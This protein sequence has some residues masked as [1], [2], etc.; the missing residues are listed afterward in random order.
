VMASRAKLDYADKL[1]DLRKQQVDLAGARVDAARADLSFV[2]ADTL[3]RNNIQPGVDI[4]E[5]ER[6]RTDASNRVVDEERKAATI[7][8]QLGQLRTVWRERRHAF[9]V[10]SRNAPAMPETNPPPPAKML[11][12]APIDRDNRLM[13]PTQF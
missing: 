1:V 7:R 2:Q 8:D 13:E 11:P 12:A 6:A 5:V 3:Q 9:D 4:G 10:A